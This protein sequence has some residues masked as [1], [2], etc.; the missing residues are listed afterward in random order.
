MKAFRLLAVVLATVGLGAG[1]AHANLITNGDFSAGLTGWTETNSCCYYTDAAGFHEGAIGTN[2]MLS[3][4]FT[5]TAGDPLVLSFEYGSDGGGGSAYQYVTF[6]NVLV[7]G[8]LVSG[9]SPYQAY[10]FALG[11]ATGLDTIT[12]SGR[13]DPSYN[14]LNNVVVNVPEPSSLALLGL[15]LAGLG[16]IKRRDQKKAA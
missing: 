9:A 5:T 4:T 16:F 3:Q 13:N 6:D 15:G 10:T 11:S 2:G 8:S 12:F 7:A 1:V 14:V